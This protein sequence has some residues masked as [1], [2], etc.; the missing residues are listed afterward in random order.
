MRS[1]ARTRVEQRAKV[2]REVVRSGRRQ[3]EAAKTRCIITDSDTAATVREHLRRAGHGDASNPRDIHKR[4][5]EE[6]IKETMTSL[7]LPGSLSLSTR[8]KNP[9][10]QVSGSRAEKRVL[11]W[12]AAAET[13]NFQDPF[14]LKKRDKYY[15]G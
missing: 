13:G 7:V 4:P 2:R 8:P 6:L 14:Q 3:E 5:K 11:N 12:F 10:S 1:G 9:N 15:D